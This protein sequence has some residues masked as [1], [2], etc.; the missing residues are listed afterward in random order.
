MFRQW[1]HF[2]GIIAQILL[3]FW[4]FRKA[5]GKINISVARLAIPVILRNIFN[6]SK[7]YIVWHYYAEEDGKSWFLKN[8]YQ[9]F[10]KLA[11]LLPA[12]K[13]EIVCVAPYWMNYFK[14]QLGLPNLILYPNLFDT[15]KYLEYRGMKKSNK[16]HFGQVSSKNDAGLFQLA[17]HLH[18]QG[19]RCYFSTN[20]KEYAAKFAHYENKYFEFFE[21]Y[22]IEMASSKFTLAFPKF[23]EGWNRVAHES[24]LVGTQ[25]IGPKLGGLGDLLYGAN[26][27]IVA[28]TEEAEAIIINQEVQA[29][30]YQFLDKFRENVVGLRQK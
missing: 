10:I 26:G 12:Q 21:D 15:E 19:Y 9:L 30:N 3:L 5:N 8:W 6:N 7:V 24:F 11:R 2:E 4:A 25:V 23:A 14:Q 22:L 16:I 29:I 27:H 17:A 20:V 1:R 13:L 28:S 18:A